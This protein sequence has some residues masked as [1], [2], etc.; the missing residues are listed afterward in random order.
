MDLTLDGVR[1]SSQATLNLV[2][3]QERRNPLRPELASRASLPRATAQ[4]SFSGRIEDFVETLGCDFPGR[5]LQGK[6]NAESRRCQAEIYPTVM[7]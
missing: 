6:V 7:S 1:M 4:K 5:K 2:I 3:V